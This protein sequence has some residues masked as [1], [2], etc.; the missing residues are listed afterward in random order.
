MVQK[1]EIGKTGKKVFP[2]AI[3]CMGLA[4]FYG[5]VDV[6]E[7]IATIREA[8]EKG[9][10]LIDTADMYGRGLS[11]QCV[12]KAIAGY[13]DK[14]IV[15]TKFGFVRDTENVM[16]MRLDGRPEYVK[17]ACD[18]SLQRLQLD[19]I[20]LYFLHR[21]DP[22]VPVEE[23]MGALRDLVKA[24]KIRYIGLSDTSLDN[25]ER[26][27]KIHPV[28]AY[29]GEYSIWHRDPELDLIPTCEKYDITFMPYCP[30]GRGFLAGEIQQFNAL[31][32]AQDVRGSLPRFYKENF[33]KNLKLL[34]NLEQFTNDK[35]IKLAQ[36]A[37]AWLLHR[38]SKIIPIVGMKKTWQVIENVQSANISL[39]QKEMEQLNQIMPIGCAVGEQYPVEMDVH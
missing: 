30:L 18:A 4:E 13:R 36:L 26:A 9:I 27:M 10:N 21:V 32:D 22:N 7:S 38:S 11:E 6:T 1:R 2:L 35:G 25:I 23:T 33:T 24:G 31:N 17:Q 8:V 37:L 19:Y 34:K 20:D 39:S 28:S 12:A 15:S 5:P 3:G 14:V 16:E 29:Q